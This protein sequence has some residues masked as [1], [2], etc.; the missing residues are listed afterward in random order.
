MS[1]NQDGASRKFDTVGYL[2]AGVVFL[3]A[4]CTCWVAIVHSPELSTALKGAVHDTARQVGLA[5]DTEPVKP[6]VNPVEKPVKLRSRATPEVKET[7]VAPETHP[8]I[9][10]EAVVQNQRVAMQSHDKNIIV[11]KTH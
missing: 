9:E 3:I 4:C 11:V 10:A 5:R 6:A 7:P 8:A 2:V 1:A